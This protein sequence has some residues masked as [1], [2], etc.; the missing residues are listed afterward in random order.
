MTNAV[1]QPVFKSWVPE[2]GIRIIIFLVM[3]P[4]LGL[5]GL[6][7]ANSTAAAGFYGIEPP[8]VQFT[9][10][11]FYAAVASFYSFET[12]LFSYIDIK[13]YLILSTGL[14]LITSY[15]CYATKD[16]I[17]LTI[18][19]FLQGLGSCAATSICI[20][21]I[22]NRL[23]TERAR[24]IGYSVF[25]CILL[26]ISQLTTLV[27]APM[28]DAVDYSALYKGIIYLYLP[29]S[30]LL[31]LVLNNVRLEKRMP[32]YQLDWAS[33]VLYA[34]A[35]C[36]LGFVLIY[37]Q[38][39]YWFA[40]ARI[41]GAAIASALLFALYGLR[42]RSLKRPY[43]SFKVFK[44][45]NYCTGAL[46]LFVLYLCRGSLNVT[47]LFF[48][49]VLGLDPLHLGIVLMANMAGIIVGVMISSRMTLTKRPMRWITLSGFLLMLIFHVW[50][51]QM[52]TVQANLDE[53]IVPLML[54]GL[55][56]GLLMVP[57]ILFMIS[58]VPPALG[59]SASGMGVLV[60]FCGFCSSLACI[61]YFADHSKTQH[62]T[63]FLQNLT[64]DNVLWGQ[65]TAAYAGALQS[66]G[67]SN[68]AAAKAANGLVAKGMSTQLQ[69]RFSMEYYQ[70][71]AVILVI[72]LIFIALYPYF[73]KTLI[74]TGN[75][76]PSAVGG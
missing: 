65:R 34:A 61:N 43:L 19:R 70:W 71:I 58:A 75:N 15:V 42:Q 76:A 10:I 55:G 17:V 20:T 48:T 36:L 44:Y 47:S 51:T 54:H 22:F 37:G 9:M 68:D 30:M 12:R 5:F 72:L 52:F 6:S 38:Q 73:K 69:I 8:D 28:L 13:N 16:P 45:R 2:W 40:D 25:Y 53:F 21:L 31:Y 62:Y 18:F 3:L 29:G 64:T 60:R 46:L 39:Y 4:S 24:E 35:I 67:L 27:T 74:N 66:K 63:R 1:D 23:Q 14:E 26:I 32:L 57:V 41:T 33:F 50:M 49:A 56:A 7:M 11:V 59:K